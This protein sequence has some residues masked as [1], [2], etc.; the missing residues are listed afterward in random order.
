M[1]MSADVSAARRLL[2]VHAHPDDET[3]TNGVTMARYADEGAHVTLV[4]CTLG[5][6]GEVLV[7][8]LSHLAAD[9]EDTL[10]RHRIGELADAMGE[11]GVTDHRFLGG[12]GRFR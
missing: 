4:T 2:A 9:Q 8:G 5:E 3:I 1:A 12:A 10:G 11:L 7:P 6:E